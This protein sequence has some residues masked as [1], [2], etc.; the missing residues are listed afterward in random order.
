M[1]KTDIIIASK[2]VTLGYC[3][4]TEIA[5]K[6]YAGEDIHTFIVEMNDAFSKKRLP[7]VK[8]SIYLILSGVMAYYSSRDED[9]PIKDTDLMN[10]TTPEELAQA[11]AAFTKLYA[12]FYNIPISEPKPKAKETKGSKGKN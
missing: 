5:F 12:E 11:L 9:A 8:K 3:Y 2:A 1:K 6:D 7:D 10:E 4:A